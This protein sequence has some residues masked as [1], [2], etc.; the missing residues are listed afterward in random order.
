MAVNDAAPEPYGFYT[1]RWVRADDE[2]EAERI[3]LI[4][5]NRE[6]QA[7]DIAFLP[8]ASIELEETRI[9][10]FHRSLL[11]WLGHRRRFGF[12]FFALNDDGTGEG[13]LRSYVAD[14]EAGKRRWR[15]VAD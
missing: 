8:G 6:L 1:T 2:H 11:H 7:K 4:E 14:D 10:P 12:A 15:E 5:I 13:P 3:A 9:E